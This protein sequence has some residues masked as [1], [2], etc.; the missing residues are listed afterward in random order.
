LNKN[1]APFQAKKI[2]LKG[3]T[4]PEQIGWALPLIEKNDPIGQDQSWDMS[5]CRTDAGFALKVRIER[6]IVPQEL[7]RMIF[8]SR[9]EALEQKKAKPLSRQEKK[10]LRESLADELLEQALPTISYIDAMWD[11]DQ[12]NLLL[13]TASKKARE[14]FEQLFRKTFTEPLKGTLVRVAPPLMGLSEKDWKDPNGLGAA[15]ERLASTVP[16]SFSTG[17][18]Y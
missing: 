5:H 7:L 18:S 14:L 2:R 3:P 15:L 1:L 16:T 17:Q 13:F 4:R 10:T 6:R 11:D 8:I 9:A 12:G